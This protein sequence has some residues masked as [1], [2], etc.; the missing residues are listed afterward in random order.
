MCILH[1]LVLSGLVMADIALFLVIMRGQ[2]NVGL[3]LLCLL[4]LLAIALILLAR[5]SSWNHSE[6]R[7]ND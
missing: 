4:T 5:H 1:R 7:T 2:S 3:A 6:R